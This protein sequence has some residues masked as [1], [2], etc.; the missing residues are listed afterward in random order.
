VTVR[1]PGLP[2]LLRDLDDLAGY[3]SDT[4]APDREASQLV[5]SAVSARAP[6]RTGYLANSVTPSGPV[7][8]VLARY[9]PYVEARHPFAA[10]AATSVDIAPPYERHVEQA[11]PATLRARY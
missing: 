8:E 6:R 3:V 11:L 2:A 5:A 4:D 10:P 7:V 1:A 9:A